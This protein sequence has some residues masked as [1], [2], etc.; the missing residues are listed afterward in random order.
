[1]YRMVSN[2]EGVGRGVGWLRTGGPHGC[3]GRGRSCFQVDETRGFLSHTPY[4][5]TADSGA[6]VTVSKSTKT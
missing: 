2:T 1:M 5:V 6:Y 3:R 4:G